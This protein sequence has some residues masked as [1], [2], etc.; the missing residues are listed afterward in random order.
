L[1]ERFTQSLGDSGD[2]TT[3]SREQIASEINAIVGENLLRTGSIS[4]ADRGRPV[5]FVAAEF[6]LTRDEAGQRVARMENDAK[7]RLGEIEGRERALADEV[8]QDAAG[9]A[10]ALFTALV[11]GLLGALI[12]AWLGARHKRRLHPEEAHASVAA[13]AYGHPVTEPLSVSVYDDSGHVVAHYLRG[14]SF[15]V[16]K[17][18]LLRFA[19]SS[20]AGPALVHSIEG[21]A[22]VLAARGIH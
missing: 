7:T 22:D 3:M 1:I 18:D 19:R 20:N 10:R 17:Q 21:L 16:S 8:A 5:S 15:L 12:G 4:D 9:A 6:G 11:L 14:V 13:P 2:P